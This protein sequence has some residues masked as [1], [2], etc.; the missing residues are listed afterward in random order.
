MIV[1]ALCAM[2]L[3]ILR[4]HLERASVYQLIRQL[5]TGGDATARSEAAVR[6]GLMGPRASFAAGALTSAL[7]DPNPRVRTAAM[8]ALVR[9]GSRS[10]R[11][12]RALVAEIV[13]PSGTASDWNSLHVAS[14]LK[15]PPPKGWPL[16]DRSLRE[17]DPIGALKVLRPPAATIVPMLKTELKRP[18]PLVHWRAIVAL[19]A[20]ASWSDPSSP[21][22]AEALLAVLATEPFGQRRPVAEALAKMDRR[23]QE[24][25]VAR[26]AEDLRDLASWRAFEAAWLLPLFADGPSTAVAALLEHVR[27]GDENRK[28]V[29]MFLLAQYRE[30][31]APSAPTLVRLISERGADRRVDI[32]RM[33]HWSDRPRYLTDGSEFMQLWRMYP[34]LANRR[35]ASMI[36]LCVRALKAMGPG[37]EWQAIR[38]LAAVLRDP[39]QDDDR[40]RGAIAALGAFGPGPAES[41]LRAALNDPSR[42]V[43]DR[44]SAA[45]ERRFPEDGSRGDSP[46]H[47]TDL[48]GPLR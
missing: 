33:L 22:L 25:A 20:V 19:S 13:S 41:A 23:V 9:V 28:F 2:G 10:P 43:R 14:S 6:I 29:A 12:L 24:K 26:L 18:N 34:D 1:V 11:L 16:S 36:A 37:V 44:A 42:L 17:N 48:S 35:A 40:K 27:G 4:V 46:G 8:Y 15:R 7:D 3:V 32:M 5:R 47:T 39:A 45:L 21:E 30:R 38:D 31:A